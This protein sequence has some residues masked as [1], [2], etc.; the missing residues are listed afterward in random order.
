MH[1]GLATGLIH[2]ARRNMNLVS[3]S[4]FSHSHSFGVGLEKYRFMDYPVSNKA[5]D[6]VEVSFGFMHSK[7]YD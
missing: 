7:A 3:V 4:P 6:I 2:I 5:L 1:P